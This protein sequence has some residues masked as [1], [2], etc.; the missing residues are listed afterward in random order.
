MIVL[1]LFALFGTACT[2]NGK[3][4]VVVKPKLVT[5]PAPPNRVIGELPEKKFPRQLEDVLKREK[6]LEHLLEKCKISYKACVE[7]NKVCRQ[8]AK[9]LNKQQTESEK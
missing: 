5:C 7:Y 2:N 4:S 3:P 9:N 6:Q 1:L 8:E